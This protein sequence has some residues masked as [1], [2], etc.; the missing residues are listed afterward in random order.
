MRFRT[1]CPGVIVVCVALSAP[2]FAQEERKPRA[3][4]KGH[5]GGVESLA[6]NPDGTMLAS[7]SAHCSV[8]LWDLATG[9][10]TATLKGDD[11]QHWSD[12]AFSPDG[13]W[14]A[15]GGW[16]N[17]VKL[18]DVGTL[19]GKLL[20]DQRRQCP[21]THVVFSP[22]GKSLASGG[23]CRDR[24]H[25]FGV[26]TGKIKSTPVTWLGFN[27]EG[28]LAMAFTPDSKV[29]ISAGRPNEIK[30][31]DLTSGEE[32]DTQKT[33]KALADAL[34]DFPA[35]TFS[36]DTR[37]L[38]TTTSA[39]HA[40]TLWEVATG[41]AQATL[42]GHTTDVTSVAFR[43]DGKILAS[44]CDDGTIK[45]WDVRAAKEVASFMAHDGAISSLAFST[46]AG[47]L[48]SGSADKMIKLWNT[49]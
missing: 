18:W 31:W 19:R 13:K 6:F 41:K 33:S 42:K 23:I 30:R 39:E 37:I 36:P 15:T 12:V 8:K 46:H 9:R 49:K 29:L 11:Q 5:T 45:L 34:F 20:L 7:A 16:F 17:K 44:G 10:N 14:L 26:A 22:D 28:V 48:A 4:L 32:R 40:I 3:V 35:A 25:V 27:A 38:A 47:E 1:V 21:E 43:P 2:L 24:M